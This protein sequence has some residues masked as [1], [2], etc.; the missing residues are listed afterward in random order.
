M[1]VLAGKV[2]VV[3]GGSIGIG[4]AT[5]RAFRDEGAKVSSPV[6]ARRRSTPRLPS[7]DLM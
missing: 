1:A 3:T 7:S 2:A 4:F 5:A 6:A